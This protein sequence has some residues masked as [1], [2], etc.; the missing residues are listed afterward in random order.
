MT[1]ELYETGDTQG[2]AVLSLGMQARDRKTRTSAKL[3]PGAANE[4]QMLRNYLKILTDNAFSYA[5]LLDHDGR[6]LYYSDSL[7]KLAGIPDSETYLGVP[8]VDAYNEVFDD[9]Y[10]ISE[11]TRRFNRVMSGEN[12]F[13]EDDVV[14]W[15]TGEKLIYRITYKR[16]TDLSGG[17][18]GI[19]VT[20]RDI[21]DIRLEEAKRRINDL[22][23]TST[24][25]C[26]IWDSKGEVIAINADFARTFG[27][28][29]TLPAEKYGE[30]YSVIQPELQPDGIPTE[31]ARQTI[32]SIAMEKGFSQCTVWLNKN[33]GTTGCFMVN[34]TRI[35]W[36]TD[37]R[38]VVYCCDLTENM[39]NE[40]RML[41]SMEREREERVQREAAQAASEAKSRFMAHMSHELRT[42]MN[43][44][45]GFA[46]LAMDDNISFKTREYLKKIRDNSTLLR[47]IVNDILDISKV[48]SGKIELEKAP[49]DLQSIFTRCQSVI[50]PCVAEK[51]L[52]LNIQVAQTGDKKLLGD[53]VRLYQVVMNLLSNA[54]K[55]TE[56]GTVSMTSRVTHESEDA[57]TIFFEVR[58]N[59]IGI[60]PA[61]VDR[62]F[63]PFIQADAST[64][65]NYGGTGLGLP[66]ARKIVELMG[67]SLT[68]DSAPGAGSTFSFE[69]T[70]Q[71]AGKYELI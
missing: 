54:V 13:S 24:I 59:G 11:M 2:T 65:R 35:A 61:Q 33:D 69:L 58:D 40:Q 47:S 50:Y 53:S 29:G 22:L 26:M 38:L 5:F 32:L 12:E 48:E 66:I 56:T 52:E 20:S 1:Y 43:S 41:E 14:S 42:P 68:V 45:L 34:I 21:T 49:F 19:I 36:L 10:V 7:L 46:E 57:V 62:M 67:G 31:T 39:E 3:R 18:N 64:T 8:I 55:F 9:N 71:T 4:T 60:D 17:F 44:I 30:I 6:I 23:S 63:E 15:P 16:V 37:Y 70:F 25:P 27:E 51:G 28:S